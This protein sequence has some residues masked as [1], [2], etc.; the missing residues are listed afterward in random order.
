M[1]IKI[2]SE[3]HRFT[4][5]IPNCIAFSSASAAITAWAMRKYAAQENN[6]SPPAD[7]LGYH[8]LRR[9]FKEIRKC[10]RYLKGEPLLYAHSK[11]DGVVVI[12][13]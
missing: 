3:E 12:Y 10:R 5:P 2:A 8:E 13:L 1:R 7:N 6:D 9:L 4:I 11:D